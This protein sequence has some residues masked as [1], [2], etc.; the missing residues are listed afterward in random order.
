MPVTEP[1][2]RRPGRPP[3]VDG[4]RR[5][6]RERLVRTGIEILTE[7][8][9]AS[10]G[11]D[12]VLKRVGVPKGSFYHYF[13]SKEAFG[14]AVIDG[15]AAYF[16]RKLDRWLLDRNR[17][18]LDRLRDF[19]TD[20]KAGLR[21]FGF[22]RGCLI[23]NLGQELGGTHDALREPLEAVFR[24]WQGRVARCLDDAVAA[25]ELVP[26]AD[27]ARL[28]EIFWI[29]WEG[30]ILRAKLVRD[31]TPVNLFTEHFFAGLPQPDH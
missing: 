11:I 17:S 2:R 10:T 6:T 25:G 30:A 28:A 23:G 13:A 27:T 7:Q 31:T 9:F 12:V 8:G 15:Y 22:R 19:V 4:S 14:R 21:R 26:E 29:G 5:A 20:G 18:P 16:A 3:K 1:S 24:D